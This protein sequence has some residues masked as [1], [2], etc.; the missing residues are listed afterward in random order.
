MCI[1]FGSAG[2]SVVFCS[3]SGRRPMHGP[4]MVRTLLSNPASSRDLLRREF[5]PSVPVSALLPT[6]SRIF[7]NAPGAAPVPF[8]DGIVLMSSGLEDLLEAKQLNTKIRTA[9]VK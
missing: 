4:V 5:I 7:R 8:A 3:A 9:K 6:V 2:T 1:D